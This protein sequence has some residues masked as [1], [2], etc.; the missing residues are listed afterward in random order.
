MQFVVPG[1]V[2]V[3]LNTP[4]DSVVAFAANGIR[5]GAASRPALIHHLREAPGAAMVALGIDLALARRSAL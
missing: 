2:S 4:T 1:F 3:A 5:E